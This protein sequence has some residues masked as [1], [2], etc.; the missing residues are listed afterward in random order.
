[1]VDLKRLVKLGVVFFDSYRQGFFI[2]RLV[3]VDKDNPEIFTF[4]V[5]L[6]DIGTATM[7]AQDKALTF[8]RWI[9]RAIED[10]TLIEVK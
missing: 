6:D 5:P 4:P 7:L 2:Y 8:M 1:M 9:R 3:V 10:K